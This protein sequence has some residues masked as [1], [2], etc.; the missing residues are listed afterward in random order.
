MS[1]LEIIV[2][3]DANVILIILGIA[4]L[5]LF[6]LSLF[7]KTGNFI[8]FLILKFAGFLIALTLV[9]MGVAIYFARFMQ[10]GG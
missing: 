8:S 3:M 2:R 1:L 6:M 10:L 9:I 5:Y 7:M 4:S